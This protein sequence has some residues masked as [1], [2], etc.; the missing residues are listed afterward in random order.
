M[1]SAACA[2]EWHADGTM[3]FLIDPAATPGPILAAVIQPA[4]KCDLGLTFTVRAASV[5]A[6]GAPVPCPIS[7]ILSDGGGQTIPYTLSCVPGG[8]GQGTSAADPAVELGVTGSAA[9]GDYENAAV[10]GGYS[11]RITFQITY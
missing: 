3:S 4:V 7:G 2:C 8:A 6:G 5:N 10:G 11:D 9:A 1:V